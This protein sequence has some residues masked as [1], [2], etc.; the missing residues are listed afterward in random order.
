MS[1]RYLR[2]VVCLYWTIDLILFPIVP[3][4]STWRCLLSLTQHWIMYMYYC[5]ILLNSNCLF[6]FF[7]FWWNIYS[8]FSSALLT[9]SIKPSCRKHY[10]ANSVMIQSISYCE[11][12]WF[13][14]SWFAIYFVD[15]WLCEY[16]RLW[17]CHLLFL[18]VKILYETL[19]YTQRIIMAILL[20]SILHTCTL[21]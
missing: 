17:I 8:F 1:H 10:N 20:L 21:L 16:L 11:W 14:C 19:F 2:G 15:L 12:I 4:V 18:I 3:L 13:T 9:S 5:W 6:F 7:F